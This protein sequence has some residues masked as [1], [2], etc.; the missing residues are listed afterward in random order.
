MKGVQNLV[1]SKTSGIGLITVFTPSWLVSKTVFECVGIRCQAT[2][3]EIEF[4]TVCEGCSLARRP[5]V[6]FSNFHMFVCIIF[7]ANHF[8]PSKSTVKCPEKL[9]KRFLAKLQCTSFIWTWWMQSSTSYFNT[10][11]HKLYKI[12]FWKKVIC[13]RILSQ[14][15]RAKPWTGLFALS[16]IK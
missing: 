4:Y 3:S 8:N 7:P 1:E 5:S 13:H 9:T 11:I 6:N 16:L 15:W 2:F 12:Q 14:R 10:A